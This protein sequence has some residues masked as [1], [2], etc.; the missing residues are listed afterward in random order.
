MALRVVE[1][2]R[3]CPPGNASITKWARRAVLLGSVLALATGCKTKQYDAATGLLAVGSPTP[4]F[5][6]KDASG[7]VVHFGDFDGKPRVVYFYPKDGTPGCTAE[8]GAFRDAYDKYRA[9]GVVV[10]GVSR[11]TEK[12][13]DEFR[14]TQALPFPL[15]AD[16]DG[17]VQKAYG[18]PDMGL[19]LASRVSFLVGRDGKVE[20]VFERVDPVVHANEVLALVK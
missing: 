16:P 12:S 20:H 18:V 17:I 1:R 3:I 6:A 14:A 15:A 5:A 19:P 7:N 10:F 4:D 2:S 8:A 11:D 13:H 9:K